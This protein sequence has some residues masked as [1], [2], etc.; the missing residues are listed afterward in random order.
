M[1]KIKHIILSLLV[2]LSISCKEELPFTPFEE[3]KYGAYARMLSSSGAFDFFNPSTSNMEVTVEFYDENKGKNVASYELT[4]EFINNDEERAGSKSA[5]AILSIPASSFVTN[6]N[7][8]PGATFNFNFEEVLDK[9]N[10]TIDSVNGGDVFRFDATV[11]KT[12]GSTFSFSNSAADLRTS[13][14]FNAL[15]RMNVP[16]VC[17]FNNDLFVGE[18][19]MTQG[20]SG[21]F[22]NFFDTDSETVTVSN[23]DA[24]TMRKF[25]FPYLDRFVSGNTSEIVVDFVCGNVVLATEGQPSGLACSGNSLLFST[26]TDRGTFNSTD[27][28]SFTLII[29]ENSASACGA[30]PVDVTFTFTKN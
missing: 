4:V 6:D 14:A 26:G 18:Y 30:G 22:G 15:F 19:T 16:V 21:V 25:T 2:F 13:A 20:N 3:L 23:P 28:S 10:F 27:D 11:V 9:F 5:V 17:L 1:K 7:G 8:L 29:K 24:N 12:D